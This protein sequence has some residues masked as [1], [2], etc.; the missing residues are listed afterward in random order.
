MKIP[1]NFGNGNF[2]VAINRAF[3]E[4]GKWE[5]IATGIADA[6]AAGKLAEALCLCGNRFATTRTWKNKNGKWETGGVYPS[7]WQGD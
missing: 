5:T 6:E 2:G 7:G 4:G 3:C 1:I